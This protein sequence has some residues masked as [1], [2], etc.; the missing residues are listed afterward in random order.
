MSL[1]LAAIGWSRITPRLATAVAAVRIVVFYETIRLQARPAMHQH[2]PPPPC[3]AVH[4]QEP[5]KKQAAPLQGQDA[6]GKGS[7]QEH[8]PDCTRGMC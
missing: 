6:V 7:V 8:R 4:I 2:I 5:R 1:V 3:L